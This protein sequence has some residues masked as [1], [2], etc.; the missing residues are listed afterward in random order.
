MALQLQVEGSK[1][2]VKAFDASL[3]LMTEWRFYHRLQ[4]S[5]GEQELRMD[6]LLDEKPYVNPSLSTRKV[7]KLFIT[8]ENKEQIE[9]VLLDAGVVDMGNATYIYGKSYDIFAA[10]EK[11]ENGNT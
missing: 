9:I 1:E 3:K 4:T 11:E 6:Y 5:I 8:G 10:G 7:S 2:K